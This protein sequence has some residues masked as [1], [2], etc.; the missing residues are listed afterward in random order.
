MHIEENVSP[1]T[2]PD[3]FTSPKPA[4]YVI[5]ANAGF[6]ASSSVSVGDEVIVP[7]LQSE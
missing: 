1:A 5:E 7:D 2:Y 4:W 3:S 6:V